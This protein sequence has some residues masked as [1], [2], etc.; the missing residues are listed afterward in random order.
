MLF[1]SNPNTRIFYCKANALTIGGEADTNTHF[2]LLS[3]L[4]PVANQIIEH[5]PDTNLI[6]LPVLGDILINVVSEGDGF[7]SRPALHQLM[8][9][10]H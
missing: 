6:P 10:T 4:D 7:F 2:A 9:F 8:G 3:K 1:L 5:L